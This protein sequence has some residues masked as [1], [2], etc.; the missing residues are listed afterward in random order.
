MAL[1]LT[2]MPIQPLQL[3]S[4]QALTPDIT[5]QLSQL[6]SSINKGRERQTLADLGKKVASGEIDYRGAAGTLANL[7]ETGGMMQML[8][9]AEAKD[10]LAREQAVS[11]QSNS[12][13][14]RIFGAGNATAQPSSGSSY[15]SAISNIESGGKYDSLGPVTKT[16][17]RAYGK[18]QVMGQNVGPWTQEVLGKAMT[19]EEFAANPQAQDAVFNAKFGNY[20]DK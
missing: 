11:Q 13:L 15:A 16:G 8:S 7:G 14:G 17:D 18:Y 4:S 10:K 5:P 19:P 12:G 9:L 3:P 2:S 20:V 6:V 1:N